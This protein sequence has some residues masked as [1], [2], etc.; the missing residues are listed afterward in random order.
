VAAHLTLDDLARLPAP[1]MDAPTKLAFAPDGRSVTFL[2]AA[3]GSNRLSLWR[4]DVRNG[5]RTELLGPVGAADEADLRPEDVLRRERARERAFG[6]T[7]YHV[8]DL[9]DRPTVVASVDGHAYRS[10]DG[11]P[12]TPISGLSDLQDAR[13]SPDGR[14]L[15]WVRDG[16]LFAAGLDPHSEPRDS[17]RLSTDA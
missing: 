13:L 15:A 5:A 17:Y 7:D 3:D 9:A 16:D 6:V 14:Q 8:A 2:A 4:W 10:V 11:A 1:G 12:A